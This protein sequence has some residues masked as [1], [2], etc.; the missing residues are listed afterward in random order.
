MARSRRS[1]LT[2]AFAGVN[3][4]GPWPALTG[5][6]VKAPPAVA[7]H[8]SDLWEASWA[9]QQ[10]LQLQRWQAALRRG[11]VDAAWD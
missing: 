2:L 9:V 8:P 6:K 7:D 10:L 11:D 3:L 4:P 5:W 1:P